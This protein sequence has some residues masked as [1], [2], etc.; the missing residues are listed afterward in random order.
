MFRDLIPKIAGQF[1]VIAP[2]YVGFAYGD[3]PVASQ[4]QYTFDNLAAYVEK[5]LFDAI[6]LTRFTIYVQDYSA[7]IGYRI[8]L[9][10]PDAIETIVVQNGN[11]YAEG[12]GEAFNPMKPF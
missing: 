1:H 8:A 3:A 6:G 11:A 10:H 9:R 4:F 7:P 5:L 2:D 12:I